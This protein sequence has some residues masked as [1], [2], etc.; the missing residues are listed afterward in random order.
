MLRLILLAIAA[1]TAMPLERP[2]R[3]QSPDAICGDTTVSARILSTGPVRA[4][5]TRARDLRVCFAAEGFTD[6]LPLHPRDWST[7]SRLVLRETRNPGDVRR[8]QSSSVLTSWAKNGTFLP[9]DTAAAAWRAAVD[10]L[11]EAQWDYAVHMIS[12]LEL[13][14]EING[15]VAQQQ[16]MLAQIDTIKRQADSL[17]LSISQGHS[18]DRGGYNARVAA[19]ERSEMAARSRVAAARGRLDAIPRTAENS[20]RIASARESVRTAED[21]A[22]QAAHRTMTARSNGRESAPSKQLI[23]D[24][25]DPEGRIATLKSMLVELDADARVPHLRAA[26]RAFDSQQ[27]PEPRLLD[28]VARIRAVLAR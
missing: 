26:L 24:G 3:A 7:R 12:R 1:M 18:R 2:L 28:A 23:L 13:E 19:A 16:W 9:N 6:S 17:R 5:I 27:N 14:E 15:I 25:L 10:E 4:V 8:M 22:R 11:I 20:E 21:M